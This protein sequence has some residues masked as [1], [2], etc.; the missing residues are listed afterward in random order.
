MIRLLLLTLIFGLF[1]EAKPI[2]NH[3]DLAEFTTYYYKNPNP[4][5]VESALKFIHDTNVFNN[6]Y[7]KAPLKIFFGRIFAD[8]PDM[9]AQWAAFMKPFKVPVRVIFLESMNV[10][11]EKILAMYPDSATKNSMLWALFCASGDMRY[12]TYIID[13][14]LGYET[15][16]SLEKFQAASSARWS[17]AININRHEKVHTYIQ[18]M[19]TSNETPMKTLAQD[20]LTKSPQN[21]AKEAIQK[22]RVLTQEG[23]K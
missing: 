18:N 20:L 21:I 6:E 4:D 7:A 23:I 13:V 16:Q 10:S 8:N 17:L 22:E 9:R 2:K 1:L 3:D 19:L 11:E 14:A 15:P 5:R 12:V